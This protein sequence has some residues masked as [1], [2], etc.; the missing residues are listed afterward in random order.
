MESKAMKSYA[1]MSKVI[2]FQTRHFNLVDYLCKDDEVMSE[3]MAF[4]IL[5][6]AAKVGQS[7]GIKPIV[8]V[9]HKFLDIDDKF[10]QKRLEWIIGFPQYIE[11]PKT[12]SYG[13]YGLNVDQ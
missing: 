1:F 6:E 3:K 10:K 4:L 5:Y 9:I 8:T 7:D 2:N 13:I 12:G 11:N